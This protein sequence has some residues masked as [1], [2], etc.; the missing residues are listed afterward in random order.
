MDAMIA[1]LIRLRDS[2]IPEAVIVVLLILHTIT[3]IKG[4]LDVTPWLAYGAPPDIHLTA[5]GWYAIVVSTTIFQFLLG[6]GLW[7]WL[8][9]TIFAFRLSRLNLRLVATHPDGHGGLGFLGLVAVAFTPISFAAS[10]VIGATWRHDVLEHGAKLAS[11][12]LDA[13]VLLLIVAIVALAPLAFFVPKLAELRRQGIF[14]Y[15]HLG[16]IQSRDFHEKWIRLRPGHEGEFL[17]APESS[18]LTDY[19]SSYARIAKMKPFAADQ[20]ALIALGISIALPMLPVV[21]AVIPLIIV[22]QDLLRA[23]R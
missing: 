22:I 8:L 14:D 18:S 6:V 2:L 10:T 23:M 7:K 20:G 12:R 19:A 15:G 21:L 4:Q 17:A 16:Q 13:I 1:S 11:F 5:A 9:W 3:G